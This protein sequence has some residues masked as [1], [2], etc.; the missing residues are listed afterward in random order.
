MTLQ[1]NGISLEILI[2]RIGTN[3]IPK[4]RFDF[5]NKQFFP[6]KWL[7]Y[8]NALSICRNQIRYLPYRMSCSSV[9][10]PRM[11]TRVS[12]L[13]IFSSRL[14]RIRFFVVVGSFPVS[15]F[16]FSLSLFLLYRHSF[17]SHHR[18]D[19]SS[20]PYVAVQMVVM[21][22][23]PLFFTPGQ[24]FRHSGRRKIAPSLSQKQKIEAPQNE[25]W[26]DNYSTG[27]DPFPLHLRPCF[28]SHT[29][30][31]TQIKQQHPSEIL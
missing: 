31:H 2:S 7:I 4:I 18:I 13:T 26:M 20:R 28:P 5:P 19:T 14:R 24:R 10:N 8:T 23:F 17:I 22:G 21:E 9:P 11:R 16:S 6:G 3:V 12:L 15:T 29:Y 1:H 25:G 27:V 30:T